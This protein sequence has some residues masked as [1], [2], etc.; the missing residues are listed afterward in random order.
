MSSIS[1]RS[2]S[3]CSASSA[4]LCIF[5]RFMSCKRSSSLR[6]FFSS[7]AS[8]AAAR[9][10]LSLSVLEASQ[11][12]SA[13]CVSAPSA[14]SKGTSPCLSFRRGSAP[15]SRSSSTTAVWPLNA[16][17]CS[18][19]RPSMLV[20]FGSLPRGAFQ[21]NSDST[22]SSF[23]LQAASESAVL[24]W[25]SLAAGSASLAN[26]F[27]TSSSSPSNANSTSS[28]SSF[29]CSLDFSTLG[30]SRPAHMPAFSV[31]WLSEQTTLRGHKRSASSVGASSLFVAMMS[32]KA[33]LGL[34]LVSTSATR[35]GAW[36]FV[37]SWNAP[38]AKAA[39]CS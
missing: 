32:R 7:S 9:S 34:N 14:I 5:L 38:S 36:H 33:S 12:L 10:S 18:G 20:E 30:F 19:V 13:A 16:A 35:S 6:T 26:S 27:C 29:C 22:V 21:S 37:R 25:L 11:P 8:W 24:P 23:P 3:P 17:R 28:V 15:R 1:S 2:F 39:W 31:T 4:S